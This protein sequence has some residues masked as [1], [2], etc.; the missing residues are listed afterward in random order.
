MCGGTFVDEAFEQNISRWLTP[1]KWNQIT[2]ESKRL[3]K[4]T[5]WESSLKNGF[6]GTEDFM[7]LPLPLELSGSDRFG[8]R[9]FFQR[10]EEKMSP[11]AKD[12]RLLLRT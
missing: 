6:S 10:N 1:G 4:E 5:H 2:D 8:V 12:G 3:W 9:G 7:R 11:K